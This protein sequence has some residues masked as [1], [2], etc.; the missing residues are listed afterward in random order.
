MNYIHFHIRVQELRGKACF[1]FLMLYYFHI[2]PVLQCDVIVI[3]PPE[4]NLKC[5]LQRDD[6]PCDITAAFI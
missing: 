3:T 6:K 4:A 2:H 5:I 1:S